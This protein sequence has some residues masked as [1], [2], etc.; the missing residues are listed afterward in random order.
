MRNI[1]AVIGAL[2]L[3][4]CDQLNQNDRTLGGANGETPV[5][6]VICSVGDTNCFVAAR[7]KDFHGCES[8]DRWASMLCDSASTP[9]K[10]VCEEDKGRQIAVTHCTL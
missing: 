1:L 4:G 3:A 7:F 10:M 9:G 2:A 6:Y 8:H 5:R